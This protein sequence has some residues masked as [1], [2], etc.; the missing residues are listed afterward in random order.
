MPRYGQPTAV[1]CK[2]KADEPFPILPTVCRRPGA[3]PETASVPEFKDIS[4]ELDSLT[5][6]IYGRVLHAKYE[7]I[8]QDLGRSMSRI[9]HNCAAR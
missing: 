6:T 9:L 2:R 7:G 8:P 1:P 4:P 5:L 3:D